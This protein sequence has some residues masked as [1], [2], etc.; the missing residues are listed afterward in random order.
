MTGLRS[1]IALLAALALGACATVPSAETD[2]AAA[3]SALDEH[4]RVLAAPEY[5]GRAPGTEG[6]RMTEQYIADQL[7][8][9]GF[10]PGAGGGEWRQP[11]ELSSYAPRSSTLT[12]VQGRRDATIS[13]EGLV[14]RM[15]AKTF[16]FADKIA[17]FVGS[18]LRLREGSLKGQVAFVHADD[19]QSVATALLAAEPG[20]IVALF[21]DQERYEQFARGFRRGRFSL[22]TQ[23]DETTAFALLS[24]ANVEILSRVL[25]TPVAEIAEEARAANGPILLAATASLVG[26]QSRETIETANVIGR[27]P[28]KEIGSGVVL[29]LSHWDH[30]G[31]CGNE[32]DEDR[33][34]NGAVDNASGV[35]VMLET[36]RIVAASGPLDR[37][38]YVV[39]TTAEELGLL[40]AEAL[41]EDPPFALPTVVAAF[42]MDTMAI[43]PRGAPITV[44]GDGRTPLD[45]GIREVAGALGRTL[46][47]REEHQQ[48]VRRQDGWAL[49]SRDV[50]TVLVGTAMGDEQA[51]SDFMSTHYHAASDEWRED[52]EL[53]GATEDIFLHVALLEYFGSGATY[54]P[55]EDAPEQ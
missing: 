2:F 55:G 10:E 4:I 17:V 33:L 8:A 50:P 54:N 21:E 5:G 3:R 30:L 35:G 22:A 47:I 12:V 51:F 34:C 31:T 14:V 43:S 39:G 52:L 53:G 20:A 23:E 26:E 18:D 24:P 16:S 36:A 9:Y 42:N 13:G 15:E 32:D 45:R 38:L 7:A 49:L 46:D 25:G 29:M 19:V 48:F 11:I 27:L 40:G 41:A 37:D 1:L 28:G 6:G 44:I